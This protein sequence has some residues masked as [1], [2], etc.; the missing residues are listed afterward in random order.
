MLRSNGPK[1]KSYW[2][3]PHTLPHSLK[4]LF[5]TFLRSV[6]AQTSQKVTVLLL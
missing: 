5:V 1:I 6:Y 3:G 4:E 2:T